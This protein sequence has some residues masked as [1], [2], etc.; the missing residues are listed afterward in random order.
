MSAYFL[1]LKSYENFPFLHLYFWL[2]LICISLYF[3]CTYCT[4]ISNQAENLQLVNWPYGCKIHAMILPFTYAN[5][6]KTQLQGWSD[7]YEG[8][9]YC[10]VF[11]GDKTHHHQGLQ[12][13]SKNGM[14]RSTPRSGCTSLL[15][16]QVVLAS[17]C[18]IR[19]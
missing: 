8:W 18:L 16:V 9:F 12:K 6:T 1:C 4:H 2:I 5:K 19:E 3:R 11:R 7:S 13:L 17:S 15:F 10:P 14:K